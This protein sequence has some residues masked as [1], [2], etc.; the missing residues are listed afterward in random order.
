MMKQSSPTCPFCH[1]QEQV[2]KHGIGSAGLQRYLCKG[3]SR[4]FQGRY[5][6][7]ANIPSTEEQVVQLFQQGWSARKI[8]IH[9]KI[10]QPTVNKRIRKWQESLQHET[11]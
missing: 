9:L 11:L 1:S 3:C 5:Y 8:S 2:K 10:S 6:Y 7:H 4:T